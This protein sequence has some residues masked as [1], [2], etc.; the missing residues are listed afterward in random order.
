MRT[1][2]RRHP[3]AFR[4]A[5][6][7]ASWRLCIGC[8]ACVYACP[9]GKVKLVDF[10]DQGLRPV[11]PTG[12]CSNGQCRD[13]LD[14]CPGIEVAHVSGTKPET[15]VTELA[16]S[17]GPVLEV[18]EGFATDADI[19]YQGSS[20]GMASAL[21]T[22]CIEHLG[23]QGTMHIQGDKQAPHV[24]KTVFSR[25]RAEL[26][27]S[28]GSRY[29]PASPCDG[30]DAIEDAGG[31]AVFIGKPCDVEALRK[32]QS[33]RP[34]LARNIGVAIG[35]FC[36][37]TP[38]TQGTLDLL[39]RYGIRPED[40]EE[41]RYRGRGWP[42]AF[43]VRLKGDET[44]QDLATYSDAW[45][46]LQAYRPYRCYLCPDGT[47]EFADISC[48][49]PWYRK[50]EPGELGTSL[51]VVRTEKGQE[52]IRR[53]IEG[54]AVRLVAVNHKTLSLSQRELQL[55]RGAI[56]GR[57]ITMKLLGVP[58]PRFRGFSLFRNWLRIPVTH[59]FRSTFGAA[60]RVF[61]RKYFRK[62]LQVF[63]KT[64]GAPDSSS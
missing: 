51:V 20:A 41:L 59:K 46:F 47:G 54:G 13:C 22:F 36:A 28:T 32:A 24:N 9:E 63:Q 15:A 38:S 3:T 21:A 56:W 45:G 16:E 19:R 27:K 10:L 49:D 23:M 52:V 1:D 5:A 12:P 62:Q 44:W 4:N 33:I 14:V 2:R 55:K 57:V 29:A 42:G 30:L 50:I 31:S 58:A 43:A 26:L 35:I 48:G 39:R 61:T 8:G 11:L 40:V 34:Q 64:S 7:V 60:R 53:A 18:W 6:D 25:T 37:G 17:W